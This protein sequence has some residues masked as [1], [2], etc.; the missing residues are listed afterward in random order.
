V[1]AIL[2]EHLGMCIQAPGGEDE[3]FYFPVANCDFIWVCYAVANPRET[4][5]DARR[6]YI[7]DSKCPG[8][9][10]VDPALVRVLLSAL[11]VRPILGGFRS[12]GAFREWQGCW[13]V[14]LDLSLALAHALLVNGSPHDTANTLADAL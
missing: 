5:K 3:F 13:Q 10:D 6:A 11:R 14:S 1:L 7:M 9:L 4:E 2:G 8:S 12:L